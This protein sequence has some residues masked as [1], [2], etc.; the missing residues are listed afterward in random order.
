MTLFATLPALYGKGQQEDVLSQADELIAEKRYNEALRILTT[1]GKRGSLEFEQAQ[2]RIQ[3]ILRLR[4]KYN[5]TAELLLNEL[6][7]YP[8]NDPRVLELSNELL[9]LDPQR[10]AETQDFISRTRELALFKSNQH[11]L[12]EILNRGQ[13]L[14]AQG[15]YAEALRTYAGG[16]DIYQE[17]FFTAGYEAAIEN[18]VRQGITTLGGNTP[19]FISSANAL[20]NVVNDLAAQAN[21]GIETPNV[22]TYQNI[23]NRLGTEMDRLTA[24]Q[25]LFAGTNTAFR[26]DLNRIRQI[27]P[28]DRDR[29]FLAFAIMLMEGRSNDSR[30]GMIGVFD[31]LWD[32]TISR[33]RDLLDAKVKSVYA[34]AIQEAE[35]FDYSRIAA[36]AE[37]LAAY[38]ALPVDLEIRWNRYDTSAQKITLFNQTVPRG[39]EEN[40]LRFRSLA[41]A[42]GYLRTLGQLGGRYTAVED[43]DTVAAW[44]DGGNAGDLIGLEQT[45]L[46]TLRQIRREAQTLVAAIRQESEEH[47]ALETRYPGSGGVEYID[48]VSSLASALVD[49]I[50]LR[51]ENSAVRRYTIANGLIENQMLT[52]EQEFQRG[53]ALLEGSTGPE[54]PDYV[55]KHPTAAAEI[56]GRMDGMLRAD[57]EALQGLISQYNAESGEFSSGSQV[58]PLH[59]S[60]LGMAG[61]LESI[62]SQARSMAASAQA[63]SAQAGALRQEGDRYYAGAQAALAQG[64]YETAQD[65]LLQAG[66]AY[67][68]SLDYEDD[69][70]TWDKRNTAIPNLDAEIARLLNEEV[71]RDVRELV[72]QISDS[73]GGGD[74]DKAEELLTRAENRWKVTQTGNT[75]PDLEYWRGMIRIGRRSGR[76][77][78]VTAPLYAEMSQLLS[79]AQKNYA[80]GRT[81]IAADRSEGVR[82]LTLAGQ[83]LQKVRLVYPMNEEAGILDLQIEQVLDPE[84]FNRNFTDRVNKAVAG[85]KRR[86]MQSYN[87]LRNLQK[88][89]PRY[90][91]INAIL[92]QAERDVGLAPPLP[93]P[94]SIARSRELTDQARPI[95]TGRVMSGMEQARSYLTEAIKL[96]PG[97][98]EA[99]DL[100]DQAA[101]IQ[102]AGRT[103]L[104]PEAERLFVQAGTALSQNNYVGALQ[105][106]NQIYARNPQYRNNSRVVDLERRAR[107]NL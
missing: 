83:N 43:R 47:R 55:S 50:A 69:P 14:I 100:F 44:R 8:V 99:R 21:Q 79:E 71:I 61:R 31:S 102:V 60:A 51:E 105:L 40:F 82:K 93:D 27:N 85:T 75:S 101:R 86:D 104:D 5:Q 32:S 87:D 78:P 65:R 3:R 35:S 26:E 67:G 53:S 57:Q 12:E 29:N 33:A 76:T 6:E 107:V 18:R 36:R 9:A 106:V 59:D 66:T 7:K 73:Y 52:R 48:K 72:S 97:N 103:I 70:A 1:Y 23:Y 42:S 22:T 84:E 74:F 45:A 58:R 62:R 24:L 41:D 13:E 38:A 10:I 54:R 63:Q 56:L 81:I 64:N 30:D 49:R 17:D 15:A 94:A 46:N 39:E 16:L 77:I 91:N 68:R 96:N 89:N 37:I 92:E 20:V 11:R 88:I 19:A 34:L 95:I 90:P 25:N 80:E 2:V 28:Q 4:D 98:Q